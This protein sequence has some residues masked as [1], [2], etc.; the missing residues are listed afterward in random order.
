M[1]RGRFSGSAFWLGGL[2]LLLTA[3]GLLFVFA[4]RPEPPRVTVQH[5]LISFAGAGTQAGRTKA[6]AE[7]LAEE[8]LVRAQN[9]EDFVALM[10]Q[11]SDDPTE[12]SY[13]LTN[14]GV[15]PKPREYPRGAM[16]QSFGD[17][18]FKLRVGAIR[19]AVFDPKLSP[20]GWHILKR[21]Q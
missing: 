7:K 3:G 14:E 6:A 19:M 2:V 13:T 10:K 15:A 12:G 21:I 20:F 18:S 4:P 17:V 16:V 9:G 1:D 11:L 5:I 8:T